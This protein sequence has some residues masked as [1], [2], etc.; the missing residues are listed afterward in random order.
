MREYWINA[1][2]EVD[3]KGDTIQVQ[4]EGLT[5]S[6]I[7]PTIPIWMAATSKTGLQIA[8]ELGDGVLLNA[9]TSP[10]YAEKAVEI[11]RDSARK[12]GRD[13]EKIEIAGMVVAAACDTKKEAYD[14]VRREIAT[15]FSPLQVDFAVR[16]RMRVGE[17]C[18]TNELI[19]TLLQSY[20]DGGIE[21]VMRDVPESVI[22]G[23]TA[24]GTPRDVQQRVEEYR[25]AGLEL[26][27]VRPA[28]LKVIK[29]T[30][31]AITPK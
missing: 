13:P 23:L 11:V 4:G 7:R 22:L 15:K 21:E 29:A 9:T 31:D 24:V 12:A 2:G 18:V 25:K 27:I 8:G 16:P 17:P 26:P 5:F 6:P 10:E 3:F 20:R 1:G 28:N 19:Q 30:L 14:I